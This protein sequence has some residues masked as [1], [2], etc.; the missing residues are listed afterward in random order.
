[1]PPDAGASEA[2]QKGFTVISES[3]QA[4]AFGS[5]IV[6]FECGI[7]KDPAKF[8]KDS[9]VCKHCTPKVAARSEKSISAQDHFHS[10]YSSTLK[11]LTDSCD[12]QIIPGVQRA[13]EILKRSPQEILAEQL[14]ELLDPASALLDPEVAEGLD[15]DALK[16]L[17][18]DRKLIHQYLKTLQDA[19]MRADEQLSTAGNPFENMTAE[20]LRAMMLKG[21]TDHC[22]EDRDMRLQLI[23]AFMDRVPTFLDEVMLVAK[24]VEKNRKAIE[25]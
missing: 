11:E 20:D 17:P 24:D 6:C 8:N 16:A 15:P 1:V 13:M 7:P 18:K 22:A 21:A 4:Q 3:Q 14:L 23:R 25:V 19:Q 5:D 10:R 9:V 12:P 2:R